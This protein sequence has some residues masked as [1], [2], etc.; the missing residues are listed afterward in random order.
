MLD[1]RTDPGGTTEGSR[2]RSQLEQQLTVNKRSEI[3][4]TQSLRLEDRIGQLTP[5]AAMMK[6][7]C[8]A[9]R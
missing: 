9:S 5:D 1:K 8:P 3:K 7:S 4:D 2:S 6:L